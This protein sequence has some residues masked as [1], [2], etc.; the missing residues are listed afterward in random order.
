M[1]WIWEAS[2]HE[3]PENPDPTAAAEGSRPR[4]RLQPVFP[5]HLQPRAERSSGAPDKMLRDNFM[6][7]N[8]IR[9]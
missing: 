1:P 4:G 2:P 9:D 6:K 3:N 5:F 7:I 8:V